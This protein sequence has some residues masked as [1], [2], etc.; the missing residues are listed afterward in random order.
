MQEPAKRSVH[1][2]GDGLSCL[3]PTSF[4][5]KNGRIREKKEEKETGKARKDGAECEEQCQR[6][7][8]EDVWI[9][10]ARR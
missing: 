8:G 4:S 3:F 6:V 9:G 2:R 1:S 10:D 5:S 7:G